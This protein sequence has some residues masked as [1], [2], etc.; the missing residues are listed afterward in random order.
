MQN[1]GPLLQNFSG[2]RVSYTKNDVEHLEMAGD[3]EEGEG[4]LL[5]ACARVCVCV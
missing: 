4:I 3:A 1:P 2:W 5:E